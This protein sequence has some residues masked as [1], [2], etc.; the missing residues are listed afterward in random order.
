MKDWQKLVLDGQEKLIKALEIIDRG[1]LQLA[2]VIDSSSK[3][4]GTVSDG[5]VRRA[6][7]SGN[8]LETEISKIANKNPMTI[9]NTEYNNTLLSQA[10]KM[11]IRLVPIV[12][13]ENVLVGIKDM[14]QIA[15]LE[16]HSNPVV[17]LAG[18]LGS[19][20]GELTK[21]TPKPMLEIGDKPILLQIIERF[22]QQGF[23][24]FYLSVNYKSEVIENYFGDG[25]KFDVSIKYLHEKTRLG[26]AGPLS[27]LKEQIE[28]TEPVL[29]INGDILTKINF[30]NLLKFHLENTSH[31]TMCVRE[32]DF[33]VPYGVVEISG[34]RLVE[35]KEKPLQSFYVNAGTYVLSP[36]LLE[37][38]PSN[39]YFD[40]TELFEKATKSE[41]RANVYPLREYWLDIGKKEDFSRAQE[42]Y[43]KEFK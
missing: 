27:L 40:M 31:G 14:T 29:V 15:S 1:G 34:D 28:I 6:L 33:K 22:K 2:V 10:E 42:D 26:T 18:G 23:S 9:K 4:I 41:Y 32:Y 35:I 21:E 17:I 37:L 13:N 30:E 25:E 43:K 38:V 39:V 11:K 8:N 12:D 20:L 5:D 36:E 19:R 3:L 24:N 7:L 16:N